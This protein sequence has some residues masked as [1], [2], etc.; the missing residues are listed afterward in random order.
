MIYLDHNATTPLDPEVRGAMDMAASVFGNP[1]SVH[2]EGQRARRLVEE[3]DEVG[4]QYASDL[5]RIARAFL[6]RKAN[7]PTSQ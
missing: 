5:L 7:R 4:R 1:S 3:G 2:A 6:L